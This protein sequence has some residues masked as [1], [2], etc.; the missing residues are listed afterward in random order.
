MARIALPLSRFAP[1]SKFPPVTK[2]LPNYLKVH[3]GPDQPNDRP[4][5]AGLP[6]AASLDA[7][8]QFW[9]DFSCTTGW[10]LD[11]RAKRRGQPTQV[12]PSV[13]DV[14]MG[15]VLENRT[16]LEAI[17]DPAGHGVSAP[18]TPAAAH[19]SAAQAHQD[20]DQSYGHGQANAPEL[21][22]GL[23]KIDAT[24]LADSARRITDELEESREALRRQ[25]M[26][27]AARASL[28]AS[29]EETTRL[30]DRIE[31]LMSDAAMACGC[32]AAVLYLLDDDTEYLL[33]RAAFGMSPG[34]LSKPPRP[35]RGSRGDLEAMVR[36]VVTID[37]FAAG[38]I[39][40]WNAPEDFAAGI[41]VVIKSAGVPI[42]TLWLFANEVIEFGKSEAAA[43]RLVAAGIALELA[44]AS[45]R[46]DH[47]SQ[48]E[49]NTVIREV[50]A[51]QHQSMP[52]GAMLAER[53]RVDG[54]IESPADWAAGWHTWDVLPDGTMM[55]AI[56]E[57]VDRSIAGA[58]HATVARAALAS[59]TG[60]RHS[61]AQLLGRVGDTL[62]H[63]STGEQLMSLLYAHVDPETGEGEVASAGNITAM[64]GSGYGY[65]PLVDGRGEPLNS[66]IDARPVTRTFRMLEGETFL[67]Y[68]AGMFKDEA[69]QR[70]L[71]E[72]LRR[73]MKSKDM[74][75]LASIRR[76]MAGKSLDQERGAVSLLRW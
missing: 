17:I 49:E 18:H 31:S 33:P 65:R 68:T 32:D 42:G 55:L 48:K 15:S 14:D 28:I 60:Y 5:K 43:A 75:P 23:G 38:S 19:A 57:A 12:L 72:Q 45:A 16:H 74:N 29:D 9:N 11:R 1:T 47:S 8:E 50:A 70:A 20:Q 52:V 59:H 39:D 56:A 37:D 62:W 3:R 58:M 71:G 67:A 76:D 21:L 27:L 61:P 34:T 41:C 53:W 73:A 51:W 36:D 24:R 44:T 7:T 25:S 26:E 13:S 6:P 22:L 2:T 54:M 10:R 69:G 64:I 35:L 66:H 40:T 4:S 46:R 63:T 30:A